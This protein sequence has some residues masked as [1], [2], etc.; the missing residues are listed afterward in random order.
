[1]KRTFVWFILAGLLSLQPLTASRELMKGD[2]YFNRGKYQ[3]ALKVYKPLFEKSKN[4]EIKWKAFF[5]T[6]ESY[7]H[8]FRYGEAIQL[9]SDTPVPSE[10]PHS[11]RILI[12]RAELYTQFLLQ[13]SG[14]GNRDIIDS[15]EKE[16]FALTPEEIRKKIENT[17][18][19]LWHLRKDLAK[20]PLLKE[21]YFILVE[22][23]D[24][25][26][27]PAVFDYVVLKYTDYLLYHAERSKIFPDADTVVKD[28]FDR[29]VNFDD[30]PCLLAA[31][32]MEDAGKSFRDNRQEAQE[33]WRIKRLLIPF[34]RMGLFKIEN[35]KELRDK[36]KNILKE[37][38]VEFKTDEAK[39]E[40][41]YEY[42]LF[43]NQ[44]QEWT[45]AVK[46]CK[47]IEKK[48]PK[49]LAGEYAKKLR[50]EIEIP[51][52][53]MNVK[54]ALPPGDKAI[55]VTTR[56]LKEVHFRAY[57]ID[58]EKMKKFKRTFSGWSYLLNYAD[59][60]WI[61]KELPKM[62]LVKAWTHNTGDKEDHKYISSAVTPPK[63]EP[64]IYFVLA[65]ADRFF[66]VNFS[67]MSASFMNI[68]DLVLIGTTGFRDDV[69]KAYYDFI[70]KNG[71]F[72]INSE[73]I[74]F[75]T[76]DAKNGKPVSG[77]DIYLYCYYS[78]KSHNTELV[79]DLSGTAH[80][81]LNVNVD[82]GECPGGSGNYYSIDPLAKHRGSFAYWQ[83]QDSLFYSSPN[84]AELFIEAD[85][86]IYRPGQEVRAKVVAVKRTSAG[87]KVLSNKEIRIMARDANGKEFFSETKKLNSYGSTDISFKIP[88]GRLLGNYSIEAVFYDRFYG[89]CNINFSVEEY[90]RPEFEVIMEEAK[91]SWKYNKPVS[92]NGSVKYYFGGP[93]PD[94]NINYRIYRTWY[95]PWCF[96][97]W[98]QFYSP[99]K[100]EIASGELAADENGN[101][102]IPFTPTP[103]PSAV[104]YKYLPDVSRFVVEVDARDEGG[105]TITGSKTY[106]AGKKAVYLNIEKAKGFFFSSK[107]VKLSIKRQ[108]LNDTPVSGKGTYEIYRITST[109]IPDLPDS[110]YRSGWSSWVPPLEVQFKDVP[111]AELY[112]Q[113]NVEYDKNGIAELKLKPLPAGTYRFVAKT[114]DKWDEEVEQSAIVIIADNDEKKSVP[115][116]APSV[117]LLE[118]DEYSV[119]D[120]A[121]LLIGSG[122]CSGTYHVEIWAG[123]H[124]LLNKLIDNGIPVGLVKIPIIKEYKGGITVRW[125]GVNNMQTYHGK[126]DIP[127]PH[128]EKKLTVELDPFKKEL[129]PGEKQ[130]WGLKIK[131]YKKRAVNGAEALVLM[132]DRSLEYY[133]KTDNPW[134][135]VLYNPRPSPDSGADSNLIYYAR[136]IPVTEGLLEK[137]FKSFRDYGEK[138][139]PPSMRT[140]RTRIS[141]G[142]KKGK[143]L[144]C[145]V[146]SE[147]E[148]RCLDEAIAG[149]MLGYDKF[150]IDSLSILSSKEKFAKKP[151]VRKAFNET[152]FFKPEVVTGKNGKGT[153]SFTAP[154]QLTGWRIKVFAFT[155]DIK[156]GRLT[157]EAVT[158]KEL[159][160]R[161][162]IP[163]FFR[164]GD[165]GTVSAV[166]H[167]ESDR[168]ISG[169]LSIEITEND[170]PVINKLKL[171]GPEKTFKI[172]PHSLKSFDWMVQIPDGITEYK[173]RVTAVSKKLSDSEERNLPILPSR[174][175]LIESRFIVLDGNSTKKMKVDEL[176]KEDSTRINESMVLQIDPQLTLSILNSIPFLINYPYE[177]VE[178]LLN[179]YVPLAVMNGIYKKYPEI[180]EAVK[181]IPKRKT[182]TPAW[183]KDDPRRLIKLIETPWMWQSE[184]RPTVW[185]I[186]DM[187]DPEIV[188]SQKDIIFE[189][190]KN[191][192]LPDGAFPWWPGGRADP[193]ITLY[194]LEGLAEARKYGV[195]VP[196][197]MIQKALMYVN[198]E[199]P[200]KLKAEERYLALVTYAAY[201]VTSFPENE[202]SEA[203]KGFKA[204][205]SWVV[206]V[207]KH[208][209]AL[210]PFGKAYTAYTY[211]RLGDMKKF[212]EFMEMAL[213]GSREDEA[214]G[215]YWTP[216]KYSWVWYSDTVEKHAFFLKMLTDLKPDDSR[217]PGMV[218]WLLFNRKGN[219]WKSTKA[220]AAAVYS[221]LGYLNRKGAIASDENFNINWGGKTDSVAVKSD[222]WLDDTIRW[223]VKGFDITSQHAEPEIEKKG[224]GTAFASLVWIYSTKKLPD[225]SAPGLLNLSRKFYRRVKIDDKYHLKPIESGGSVKVGDTIEVHLKINTRS[226]FEYMHLKDLKAAGFEA[227]TLL[228]GWKWDNLFRYEEP[229]D[230]LTNFFIS[231]LPHGEY[232]LKYRLQP[233]KP[234][235]YR[236]GAATLQSMYA[237]E[238]TAHSSGFIINVT[239]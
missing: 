55:T 34:R 210:T 71:P 108:T 233:T 146:H 195:S 9:L 212:N 179:K 178:Q 113:G 229:R 236:I 51:R 104:L 185:P 145:E 144:K 23:I 30:I 150:G 129:K 72:N 96:R 203:K 80:Q 103:A 118:N 191:A 119:G 199:I 175:R 221:L 8:L 197:D 7:T 58:P 41:L 89:S 19:A 159:M 95:L 143:V 128:R 225:E 65:C 85:R 16:V 140:S 136:D 211:Y 18:E 3:Q 138:P 231:W 67:V 200:L 160:V 53:V 204:A 64:G 135:N 45:E 232:I 155:P 188:E 73:G 224:R 91:D 124:L 227:E 42:A 101:F 1:M 139:S 59:D 177:C 131:D 77:A 25:G 94:A 208:S 130:T 142:R 92:I 84:F 234:G 68:T 213:D 22:K 164:E 29:E 192:Q 167:N 52:L 100:E 123:R 228:S 127:I 98:F 194:V 180:A 209:G 217:I 57:E 97:Y 49:T 207:E 21:D 36:A 4:P 13:Y 215:V 35:G 81:S 147:A 186:T 117:T 226:Q 193:Y 219:V 172:E 114:R 61:K 112:S 6:C 82:P 120:T 166:V 198:K 169:R 15:D 223:S 134:L 40:A 235:T 149:E 201:V 12:L 205:R 93:V 162:D 48:F 206:Y 125:F 105:R 121:E 230:S 5:R 156:E 237:P 102:D 27:Y 2:D 44:E 87:F 190:L 70:E 148:Y 161:A 24:K 106:T 109:S 79:T 110:R 60:E 46:V 170:N 20:M 86:P 54:T 152:A 14:I 90:K 28:V 168:T 163:R 75:Y 154:E 116:Y 216:E 126:V 66:K 239:K 165:N 196:K 153:F 220:S 63:L 33:R 132:Y 88:E 218:K 182:T 83:S 122:R 171:T 157:E 173:I 189:K 74:H 10:M 78:N 76:V 184:G 47:D 202:F 99:G 214:A 11:A 151:E 181:K 176:L 39:A 238:M 38:S 137:I 222:E 158:K 37:W 32:L 174:Q 62:K 26:M 50:V 56:N 133:M 31:E 107:P 111:N 17:F 187:L 115:V 69:E 183:E 43:L 141:V